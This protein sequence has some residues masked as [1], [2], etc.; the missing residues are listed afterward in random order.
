MTPAP[1]LAA[2][3]ATRDHERLYAGLSVL[4][5]TA[6]DGERC[7]ALASFGSLDLMLEG[8]GGEGRFGRSLDEL[9]ATALDLES[10][11]VYACAASVEH[12]GLGA[13]LIEQRLTGV[14]STPRFLRE[15][16]GAALIFV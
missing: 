7:M 14:L 8:A 2:V 12:L 6:V 9:L 4:V 5:S 11:E 16:R 3:L 13:D 15:A 10:L 1:S